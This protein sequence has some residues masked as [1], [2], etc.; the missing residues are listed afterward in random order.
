MSGTK[1]S[2]PLRAVQWADA[3]GTA[4]R[5]P[6]GRAQPV[7]PPCAPPKPGNQLVGGITSVNSSARCSI[8]Y[9]ERVTPNGQ[10]MQGVRAQ[11]NG[12]TDTNCSVE[13]LFNAPS[14]IPSGQISVVIYTEAPS[15]FAKQAGFTLYLS[16]A[17]GDFFTRGFGIDR[18]GWHIRSPNPPSAAGPEKWSVGGGSPAFGTTSFNRL[19]IRTDFLAGEAP[20]FE[21]YAIYEKPVFD[22][23]PPI[24]ITFDDG[25]AT[26]FTNGAPVLE[27]YG[28]TASFGLIVDAIGAPSYMTLA[29]CKTLKA[30]GHEFTAHG[31]IGG[32]GSLLNYN[33]SPTRAADILADV[34]AARDFLVSNGL[35]SNGSERVYSWP[36]GIDQINPGD[37]VIHDQIRAAGYR[38]ARGV[39]G[40][41]ELSAAPPGTNASGMYLPI[42]GH[43]WV[44]EA[45]EPTNIST[46][47]TRMTENAAAGKGSILMFHRVV[48]GTPS[49][50]DEITPAR[51]G[52]LC[53][54]IAGLQASGAA[55]CV[56]MSRLY[57][58][59]TGKH[60]SAA[61]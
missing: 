52:S 46:L 49:G 47:Q 34:S 5:R 25:Y 24:V 22:G 7:W 16:S 11:A 36:Q 54:T 2:G 4:L 56:S 43:S 50:P 60:L 55:Q 3:S 27:R 45:S 23:P 14:T 12:G 19:N 40:S 8:T 6:D 39:T 31:P 57:S 44:S 13:L 26:Q 37:P 21:V 17:A 51:L 9:V 1:S 10:Q 41:Y 33:G 30:R 42:I 15:I 48:T 20:W 28:L 58:L 59:L 29:Q 32:T 18:D 38:M 61:P 53:S 35:S